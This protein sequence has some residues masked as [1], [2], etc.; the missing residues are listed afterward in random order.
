MRF[1]RDA[2][3]CAKGVDALVLV[4]EWPEYKEMDLPRVARAMNN[5]VLLDGRNVFDPAA[6]RTLGFVYRSV[7]RP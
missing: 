7:G 2:Y 5:P 6:V 3:D 1:A 4:T